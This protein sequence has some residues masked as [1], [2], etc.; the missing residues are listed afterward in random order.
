MRWVSRFYFRG[1]AYFRLFTSRIDVFLVNHF[2]VTSIVLSRLL[3]NGGH[4]FI[5]DSSC[6]TA[7]QYVVTMNVVSLSRQAYEWNL[8]GSSASS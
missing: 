1:F 3:V 7:G 2:R 5:G 4:A 8:Y 6:K